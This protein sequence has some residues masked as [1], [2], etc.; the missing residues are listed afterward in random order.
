MVTGLCDVVVKVLACYSRGCEF[1]IRPF[2]CQVI[3]L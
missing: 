3:I 1:N 2:S